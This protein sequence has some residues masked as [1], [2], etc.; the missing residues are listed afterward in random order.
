M[1]QLKYDNLKLGE[2][3]AILSIA[4]YI[5]LSSLKLF[6]GY[7]ADSEALKADGL[8]NATDI[9]ASIAVLIDSDFLN[10]LL[11]EIILMVTGRQKVLL[12]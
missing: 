3:G 5:L 10:V 6:I 11:T 4:A 9:V 7:T 12:R 1:D 8:N 2:K